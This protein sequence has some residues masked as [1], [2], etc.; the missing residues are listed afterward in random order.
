M[1]A[2]VAQ[3]LHYLR[4]G[5]NGILQHEYI[6]N[7]I[8]QPLLNIPQ[9]HAELQRLYVQS[10]NDDLKRAVQNRSFASIAEL[11]QEIRVLAYKFASIDAYNTLYTLQQGNKPIAQHNSEIDLLLGQLEVPM[12]DDLLQ[13]MYRNSLRQDV[14]MRLGEN[15]EFASFEELRRAV[16]MICP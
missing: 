1:L 16:A 12:G 4:Q 7:S 15:R 11:Q 9:Y 8:A 5:N 2:N 3:Q 6:F 13:D 10:L 14:R